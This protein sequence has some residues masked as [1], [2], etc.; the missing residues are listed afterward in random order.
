MKYL[1]CFIFV[2]SFYSYLSAQK[3]RAR[4]IGIPFE[5]VT[6]KNNAITDVAGVEVGYSTIISGAG[7]NIR[8][9][10]PS[11][12]RRNGHLTERT[13]KQSCICKLV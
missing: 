12:D 6:G 1:S 4:E 5:G 9:K 10:G 3:P 11:K 8:G 13:H 2:L 7:K